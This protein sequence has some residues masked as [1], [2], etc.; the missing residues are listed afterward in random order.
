MS[1]MAKTFGGFR[2]ALL[3]GWV[4]LFVIGVAYA[5]FKDIP[6]WAALPALAAFLIEYPFYLVPAFPSV[7]MRVLGLAGSSSRMIRRISS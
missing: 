5:R 3:V 2:A 1:A 6:G 4:L 7:L